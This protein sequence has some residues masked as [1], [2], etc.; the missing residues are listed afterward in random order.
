M[1]YFSP[2]TETAVEK[3]LL[4]FV[5]LPGRLVDFLSGYKLAPG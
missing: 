3:E 5:C 1:L 2:V 4:L